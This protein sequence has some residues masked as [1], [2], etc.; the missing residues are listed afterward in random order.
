[1]CQDLVDLVEVAEFGGDE[2]EA[3]QPLGISPRTQELQHVQVHQVPAL[4]P[5]GCLQEQHVTRA[6]LQDQHPGARTHLTQPWHTTTVAS[7]EEPEHRLPGEGEQG[8]PH[9]PGQSQQRSP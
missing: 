7:A 3:T 2:V 9:V 4:V 6:T 8:A 5:G 1:M